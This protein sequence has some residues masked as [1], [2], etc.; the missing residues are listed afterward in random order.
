MA[1]GSPHRLRRRRQMIRRA[2]GRPIERWADRSRMTVDRFV[3]IVA[4]RLLAPICPAAFQGTIGRPPIDLT[5]P[6]CRGDVRSPLPHPTVS[7]DYPGRGLARLGTAL[8]FARRSP[9]WTVRSG[10]GGRVPMIS[11]I[12]PVEAVSSTRTPSPLNPP[13]PRSTAVHGPASSSQPASRRSNRW[14]LHPCPVVSSAALANSLVVTVRPIRRPGGE[15]HAA[16]L[17]AYLTGVATGV[18]CC[19]RYSE[20]VRNPSGPLSSRICSSIDQ[21]PSS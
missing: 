6:D 2:G 14:T 20:T 7:T 5:D 9:S 13:T 12:A 4:A 16:L 3:A 17:V 1:S 11:G 21:R 10:R 8:V 18:S 15:L 19:S